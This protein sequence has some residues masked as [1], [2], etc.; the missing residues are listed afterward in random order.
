MLVSV[1]TIIC[2]AVL[3]AYWFRY[4]CILLLQNAE[5]R[6]PAMRTNGAPAFGFIGIQERIREGQ[7]L[8]PLHR[9]LGRDYEV[10]MYLVAHASRLNLG[11]LEDRVLVLD[12]KLMQLQ[13]RL[14]R[15]LFPARARGALTEMA[16]VL[17]TLARRMGDQSGA[18][19][20]A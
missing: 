5:Q 1:L 17:E 10:L 7:E 11:S 9:A 13:F 15:A 18:Y 8:D 20:R 3:L 16:V 2:S 4:T 14:T 12:Y 19:N 6:Q